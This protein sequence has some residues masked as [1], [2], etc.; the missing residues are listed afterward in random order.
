MILT[1]EKEINAIMYIIDFFKDNLKSFHFN[2]ISIRCEFLKFM[3][4]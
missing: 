2:K 3:F 1:F 4:I